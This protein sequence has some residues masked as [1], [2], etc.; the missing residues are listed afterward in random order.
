MKVRDVMIVNSLKCCSPGT[1]IH[2]AA[3]TM[4]TINF[5]ALPVVDKDKKVLGMITDRDICLSLVKNYSVPQLK[6]TVSQIMQKEVCT[7]NSNDDVSTAFGYMHANQIAH[8]PVV[9]TQGKLKG[10]VSLHNLI[11]KT[12]GFDKTQKE[13]MAAPGESLMRTI[14]AINNLY[15]GS[16]ILSIKKI[17]TVKKSKGIL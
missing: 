7:V 10:I 16:N 6:T 1:K 15:N 14:H 13:T 5:G 12:A 3:K 8:L 4:S 9:D 2:V 11:N 17:P